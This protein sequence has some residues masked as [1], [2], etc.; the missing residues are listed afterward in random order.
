MS[1][2]PQDPQQPHMQQQLQLP[3]LDQ[4]VR[5]R[6]AAMRRVEST[7][8]QL[9]EIYQQFSSLVREQGDLVTRIDSQTEEAELNMSKRAAENTPSL[10]ETDKSNST[11]ST[12]IPI[13]RYYRQR[14]H[15]NPWSDHTLDYPPR[16]EDMDWSTLYLPAKIPDLSGDCVNQ[17][18]SK[19]DDPAAAVVR[20]VDVGCGYGALLFK[21]A[22]K[23]PHIRSLG[24]EIRLKVSDFVQGQLHKMFFLYPDPHFKRMKHKWRIISPTLL[25][26][27]AY[28]LAVGAR[29]Y[30][31]TDV[32]ELAQWMAEC[33]RNHPLFEPRY[34]LH[35]SPSSDGQ[36][37]TLASPSVE[38]TGL[39]P[40]S[41]S[42]Q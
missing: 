1:S 36:S 12:G 8:V 38:V 20:F 4:E 22:L 25:D 40:G 33:M 6:D 7:I 31:A 19:C 28:V 24:L 35:F 16:P 14:A 21:L 2:S 3:I 10:P 13:K 42:A 17:D 23:F 11:V 29:V 30:A 41:S 37:L 18:S 32:P 34:Y 5:Q 39:T 15:C 26:V 9:G 27:Y